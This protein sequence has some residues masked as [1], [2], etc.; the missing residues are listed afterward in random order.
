MK[1]EFF[2][3]SVEE[4]LRRAQEMFGVD[5]RQLEYTVVEGEF[6]SLL[7]TR[8]LAVLV[9]VPDVHGVSS[10]A[11]TE[12]EPAPP[13]KP[14][15]TEW[16]AYLLEGIF[17]RMG[18]PVEINR[19]EKADN[20]VMTVDLPDGALDL[21]RGESRELRGAIQHLVNRAVTGEGESQKRFIVDI[22]GT[23]EKR[24]EKMKELAGRLAEK[25]SRRGRAINVHLMDSQ[26]RRIVHSALAE[27]REVS[28]TGSGDA[29]F[30]VLMV[31][32]K[33]EP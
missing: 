1:R 12:R 8:K 25:V 13:R 7:R 26:D 3:T 27:S 31:K 16:A 10:R 30:R 17:R 24:R 22:G 9:E 15:S 21:R 4:A 19:Q 5:P 6:G 23:L 33:K 29:Q 32:P 14:G 11:V 18:I 20:V 28:T 2:A